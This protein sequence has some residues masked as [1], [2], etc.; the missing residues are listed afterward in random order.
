MSR[1]VSQ[2]GHENEQ[3]KP[4]VVRRGKLFW[5]ANIILFEYYIRSV[6]V[7]FTIVAVDLDDY[8]LV[9]LGPSTRT[10]DER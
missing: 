1:E 8:L 7:M 6:N 5:S 2:L 4:T 3:G 10:K 9:I